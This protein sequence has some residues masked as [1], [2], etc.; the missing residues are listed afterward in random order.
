M[1]LSAIPGREEPIKEAKELFSKKIDAIAHRDKGFTVSETRDII[2]AGDNDFPA[3]TLDADGKLWVVWSSYRDGADTIRARWFAD[4]SRSEEYQVSCAEGREFQ[5]TAAC[6]AAGRV[7]FGWSAHR[8]GV[9]RIIV[10]PFSEGSFGEEVELDSSRDG[11]FN[12]CLL[13]TSEGT[14]WAAWERVVGKKSQICLR[15]FDGVNWGRSMMVSDPGFS[16][17]RPALVENADGSVWVAWDAWQE[18]QGYDIFMR[19]YKGGGWLAIMQVTRHAADDFHPALAADADGALWVAFASN[20]ELK[21]RW[22]LPRWIYL[23]R[24]DGK[25]FYYPARS[26]VGRDLSKKGIEQSWE[27]P[28][29]LVDDA[30]RIWIFGRA[31][32]CFYAQNLSGEGWSDLVRLGDSEWGCRGQRICAVKDGANIYLAWRGLSGIEV[33]CIATKGNRVGSPWLHKLRKGERRVALE[34]IRSARSRRSIEHNGEKLNVYFGDMHGFTSHSDG[35]GEVDEYYARCRDIYKLDFAIAADH[36]EFCGK[37]L[38]AAEVEFLWRKADIYYSPEQFVTFKAYEWTGAAHPGAG[39]LLIVFPDGDCEVIGRSDKRGATL[40]KLLPLLREKGAI[41]V[42]LHIGWTGF[43]ASKFDPE[44]QPVIEIC[45]AH[46]AFEYEGNEPIP[47]RTDNVV[48]GCFLRDLLGKGLK[49]GFCAGSSGHGLLYHHGAC[50]REDSWRTGHTAVFAP[51]LTREAIFDALKRRRCYATSGERIFL[52]FRVN[53]HLMGEQFETGEELH[54]TVNA[55]GAHR[56]WT[57]EFISNG[58]TIHT[59]K[60]RKREVSCELRLPPP[61]GESYYYVRIHQS[62]GEMAWSSPIWVAPR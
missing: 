57:I 34:N 17:F 25:R 12:P 20:R 46:G 31:S 58:K 9:W 37:R 28:S 16:C 38:N 3:L 22:N 40:D 6:D 36:E 18:Q 29:I 48:K 44:V 61:E 39:H 59:E 24:Y 8:D 49:F 52:D 7:W 33:A 32:H 19:G 21:N 10:R 14:L 60:R 53:G 23:Y 11:C 15:V 13:A 35:L 62:R 43:D 55:V 54:L 41:A 45:S 47:H 30:G 50:W 56:I 5:C 1:P 27:F 26:Q 4:D 42:P 2:S 51:E